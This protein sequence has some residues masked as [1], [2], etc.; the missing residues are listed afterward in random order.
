MNTAIIIATHGAAAQPLLD[1]TQMI[2]GHQENVCAISFFPGENV[3][4]LVTKFEQAVQQMDLRDGL[5]FMVDIYAGSPFNAASLLAIKKENW[6]VVTGVN[7]PM[8][9]NV[10]LEREGT[11]DFDQLI[12][13]SK[14]MAREGVKSL[15]QSL[16]NN[17]AEEEL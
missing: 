14:D 1:T 6:D 16:K 11:E 3:D 13:I 15:K 5:M 10:F 9:V 4:S 8:L 2:V 7:V 17:N 12:E